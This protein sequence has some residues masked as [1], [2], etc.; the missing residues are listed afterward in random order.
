MNRASLVMGWG[1]VAVLLAACGSGE[2]DVRGRVVHEGRDEGIAGA[3]IAP[4]AERGRAV[5]TD[6]D[7]WF[8]VRCLRETDSLYVRAEGFRPVAVALPS[9]ESQEL[10]ISLL[11][12]A[13]TAYT[14]AGAVDARVFLQSPRLTHKRLSPNE[15]R[16]I[17][18]T[19]FPG[20]RIRNGDIVDVGDD[21]EWYFEVIDGRAVVRVYLDQWTGDLRS[22]DS[23]DPVV[24]RRLRIMMDSL[25]E[26]PG[27]DR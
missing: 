5:R 15:A 1:L 16:A 7:G 18:R 22:L 3:W 8:R 24:D 25:R 12:L 4:K 19:L 17:V 10:R 11:P 26:G 27:D 13:D 9:Q 21:Q 2:R 20:M 14:S 6:P 23:D